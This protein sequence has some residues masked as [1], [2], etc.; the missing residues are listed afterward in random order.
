MFEEQKIVS[1]FKNHNSTT[2]KICQYKHYI[3]IK[4]VNCR[5]LFAKTQKTLLTLAEMSVK[6][7]TTFESA[8]IF[9]RVRISSIHLVLHCRV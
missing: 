9:M 5:I 6:M 3:E 7:R 2:K 8:F 1:A 4:I